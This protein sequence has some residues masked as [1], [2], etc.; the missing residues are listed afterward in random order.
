MGHIYIYIYIYISRR[1]DLGDIRKL[2][3]LSSPSSSLVMNQLHADVQKGSLTPKLKPGL[4]C[5]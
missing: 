4:L 5:I 2:L 1:R 3:E